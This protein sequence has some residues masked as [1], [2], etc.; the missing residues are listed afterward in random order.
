MRRVASAATA[1]AMTAAL[2]VVGSSTST[3]VYAPRTL[4]VTAPAAPGSVV[5]P[6]FPVDFVT[7]RWEGEHAPAYVRLR[8]GSRW[9]A[10]TEMQEDGV[11]AEGLFLTAPF[12]ARDAD[13]VQVRV[14]RG[15]RA[16]RVTAMNTT[17]GQLVRVGT[18]RGA[19][20]ATPVITRAQ[21]GADESLRF[22]GAAEKFPPV[23]YPVQKLTVH[24]TATG[25]GGDDP[26]AVV[27]AIYQGHSQE[28]GDIGYHFLV[29]PGGQVY[30]GRWSGTDGVP[31]R[32]ATGHGVTAA[33]VAGY[34]SA[35][36]GVAM[37][38]TLTSV[39]PT[40]AARS[41]L[42]SLLA[43]LAGRH[44]LAPEGTTTY[45]NPAAPATTTMQANISGHRDWAATECPGGALYAQLPSIRTAVATLV[46]SDPTPPLVSSVRTAS[47]TRRGATVRWNTFDAATSRVEYWSTGARRWSST[48]L[49]LR[50]VHGIRLSEL[51]PATTY[52]FRVHSRDIAGNVSTS[53]TGTFTTPR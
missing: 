2:L 47:L 40:A 20:A 38:G 21:W 6:T 28:F 46:A 35:N 42:E 25:D 12:D 32:D 44:G 22:D 27:R 41:S 33:H 15:V 30:E 43:D 5:D 39:A 16:A 18:R 26:A 51:R 1:L 31:G 19:L 11:H 49:R 13:A 8:H 7:V 10:W 23:Y 52:Y 37:L 24:H 4:A 36:L 14:P 50:H 34:N 17:D 3:A 48:V 53:A 9:S 45:V 29:G